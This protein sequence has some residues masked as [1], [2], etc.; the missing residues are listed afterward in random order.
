MRTWMSLLLQRAW[1]TMALNELI[2]IIRRMYST[3]VWVW[4]EAVGFEKKEIFL[5]VVKLDTLKPRRPSAFHPRRVATAFVFELLTVPKHGRRLVG[6]R[7]LGDFSLQRSSFLSLKGWSMT[8][9][10]TN[11]TICSTCNH[12]LNGCA[13]PD[14]FW[15]LFNINLWHWST[16][17]WIYF[18]GLFVTNA[19]V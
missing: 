16:L 11:K 14:S 9:L 18:I 15:P 6:A 4:H 2:L 1:Y 10:K 8:S 17:K 7:F 19:I 3:F 13:K 12:K 5:I